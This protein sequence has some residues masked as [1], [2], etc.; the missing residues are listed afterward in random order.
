MEMKRTKKEFH[1]YEMKH[2]KGT[3]DFPCDF[4]NS[5]SYDNFHISKDNTIIVVFCKDCF[6][7]LI[8]Q[9]S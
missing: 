6:D 1:T 2:Y 4:C 8:N 9:G 3:L 5:N 7:K